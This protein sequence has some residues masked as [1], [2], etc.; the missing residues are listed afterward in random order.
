MALLQ[1]TIPWSV[2]WSCLQLLALLLDMTNKE[3]KEIEKEAKGK[4]FESDIMLTKQDMD[5]V[6]LSKTDGTGEIQVSPAEITSKRKAVRNRKY[7]WPSRVVPMEASAD[8]GKK[9]LYISLNCV[10]SAN[11]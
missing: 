3:E 10:Y 11:G 5:D 8:F 1:D 2:V 7:L 4:L 9:L 6:D